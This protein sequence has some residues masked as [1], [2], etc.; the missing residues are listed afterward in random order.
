MKQNIL[1]RAIGWIAPAAGVRRFRQR[2]AIEVMKRGY[3]GA[4]RDRL[5][6]G[7]RTAGTSADTEIANAGAL[8]R[9]RSRDL[10]RNNPYAA[11]ALAVLVTHAVGAG[12]VPR[13]KDNK[14]NALFAEWAKQCDAD[15][16]SDFFGIQSLAV[17]EMLEAGTGMVRKRRRRAEDGLA[18]PLQ[19]QLLEIDHLDTAKNGDLTGSKRASY[20]IEYDSIGKTTAYWLFPQHPGNVAL[21]SSTSL[22]SKPIPAEDIAFAFDKMRAGQTQGVPWGTPAVKSLYYLQTYEQADLIRIDLS[23]PRL[24]P[25]YDVYATLVFAA[26]PVDVRDV[27]V[28]GRWLM[29]GREVLSLERKKVLRDALQIAAAFKA[30][31][32]RIDAVQGA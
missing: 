25:V 14:V 30:E 29:R 6:Y 13:S 3:D 15:G 7:W 26:M 28:A 5:R 9:D 11:N 16:H 12:I 19:L 20:G 2:A 27:M 22:E 24:Q 4:S 23:A 21:W 10:T 18:V 31:M 8:L 17:R 1:D 32:A